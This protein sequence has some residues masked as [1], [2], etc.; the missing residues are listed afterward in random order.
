[1]P[2]HRVTAWEECFGSGFKGSLPEEVGHRIRGARF[3]LVSSPAG[4]IVQHRWICDCGQ[5]GSCVTGEETAWHYGRQHVAA[6]E[7]R[8]R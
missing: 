2:K 3:A 6:M 4:T 7:R 1:M 5:M 8:D